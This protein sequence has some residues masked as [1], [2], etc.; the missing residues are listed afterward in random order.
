MDRD[1]SC[2]LRVSVN[3][4][5]FFSGGEVQRVAGSSIG[6][7]ARLLTIGGMLTVTEPAGG[8]AS[9]IGGGATVLPRLM[10]A[11]PQRNKLMTKR[12]AAKPVSECEDDVCARHGWSQGEYSTFDATLPA[13]GQAA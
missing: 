10:L 5:G 8:A 11:Y 6:L 4:T 7:L 12:A 2:P 13:C 1:L 9:E 3:G